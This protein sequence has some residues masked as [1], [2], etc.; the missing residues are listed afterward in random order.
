MAPERIQFFLPGPAY[1][2]ED[3]RQAL[4]GPVMGHR[5]AAFK[6]IYQRLEGGL[7]TLFRTSGDVFMAS[8]SATLVMEAAVVSTVQKR[9]LNL[10][11]GAFSERWHEVCRLHGLEAD[12][13][14]VPWGRAVDPD[15]VRAALRRGSYEAV[16]L[17]HN[18]TSTGVVNPV[19]EI[20]RVVREESDALLLVDC[21]SSLGGA[22]FETDAWG[23][24]I[25]L[26][27]VQKAMALPPGLVLFT[28]S[29][30]A[31]R[32]AERVP[33]RGYYTDVLRYRDKHQGHGPITTPVVSLVYALDLQLDRILDEGVEERWQRHREM[34]QQTLRWAEARGFQCAAEAGA[35]SWTVTCLRP[36][37]PLSAPQWVAQLAERGYTIASGYGQWKGETFRIGHM[38]D[39]QPEDLEALFAVM[40]QIRE[41]S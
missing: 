39:V 13:V 4:I 9:V 17:V 37:V 16:T 6:A 10:T 36:P 23:V 22:P 2:R 34:Q 3:V 15:L 24:D 25:A 5:S 27:G 12:R 1:V 19:E 28:L 7:P 32:Q 29:E 31:A 26:A 11:S 14:A 41:S 8:S 33:R 30:R 20:S 18:E 38:G 40:D 21:V 35:R